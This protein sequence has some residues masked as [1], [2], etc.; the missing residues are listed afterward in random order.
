MLEVDEEEHVVD[1]NLTEN[2]ALEV[3][4]IEYTSGSSPLLSMNALSRVLT[5]QTMRVSGL[6]D[7]KLRYLD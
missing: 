4:N 5:Y 1:E 7:K 6:Y 3:E 2:A